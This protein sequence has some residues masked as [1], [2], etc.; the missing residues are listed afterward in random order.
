VVALKNGAP[1][2]K[3][4]KIYRVRS[5]S[6][7]DDY[8]AMFEVLSRRFKRGMEARSTSEEGLS[9]TDELEGDA[10]GALGKVDEST[11]EELGSAPEAAEGQPSRWDLP[12]LFVVDGGRGQLGVALAAAADLNLTD[13]P[14]VGLAKER[15]SVTGDKFVD[16][17]YLPGQKNPIP[18]RPNTPELFMLALARDEAHRFA[19]VHR[20]KVGKKR[21]FASRLDDVKGI[22]PKIRKSL[23]T[24]LGSLDAVCAADD[25]TLL[26]VTG[27]TAAR[28]A[29]LRAVL[30]PQQSAEDA[31]DE[32]VADALHD[33]ESPDEDA[34]DQGLSDEEAPGVE[35]QT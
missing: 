16:R 2:K 29:A 20:K 28:L 34:S 13:L 21:R 5:V 24:T 23:L 9:D 35:E 27:M 26:A 4:Y 31:V 8:Q 19:N 18:L 32:A 14:I 1:D 6:D 30:G 7:G 3:N 15:E 10:G 33:E 11:T 17:V 22:G 12:D 25:A